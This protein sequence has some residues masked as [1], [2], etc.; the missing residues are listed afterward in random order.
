MW[1]RKYQEEW[2]YRNPKSIVSKGGGCC[3]SQKKIEGFEQKKLK[4]E[5]FS[6]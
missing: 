1:K 2:V 4:M 5:D 3:S 6:P